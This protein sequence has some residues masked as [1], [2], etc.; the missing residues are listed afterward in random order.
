MTGASFLSYA[1]AV[2][3]R[4]R[5]GSIARDKSNIPTQKHPSR[6]KP[7]KKEKEEGEKKKTRMNE[8]IAEIRTL[9]LTV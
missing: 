8:S 6:K 3:L 9:Y 1:G 4:L 7:P 2:L 5:T